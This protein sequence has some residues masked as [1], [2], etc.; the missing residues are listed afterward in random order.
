MSNSADH[1]FGSVKKTGN[2]SRMNHIGMKVRE[3]TV[4][5]FSCPV[6][7]ASIYCDGSIPTWELYRVSNVSRDKSS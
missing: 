1:T 5:S 4:V 2:K 6:P 7:I 3:Y